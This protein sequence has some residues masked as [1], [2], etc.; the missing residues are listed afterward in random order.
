MWARKFLSVL[1]TSLFLIQNLNQPAIAYNY[2]SDLLVEIFIIF[3]KNRNI[4]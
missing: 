1:E 2:Y 4:S 3:L